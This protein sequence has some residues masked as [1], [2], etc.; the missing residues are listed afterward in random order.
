MTRMRGKDR[1]HE[2]EPLSNLQAIQFA[3]RNKIQRPVAHDVLSP[4]GRAASHN[5]GSWY[6]RVGGPMTGWRRE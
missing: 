5:A 4:S 3:S 2:F 6:I 1:V